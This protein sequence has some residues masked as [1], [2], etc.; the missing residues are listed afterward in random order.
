LRRH[1]QGYPESVLCD[2]LCN[3]N[4]LGVFTCMQFAIL[5]GEQQLQ[6]QILDIAGRHPKCVPSS[7]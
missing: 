2:V 5:V 7:V 1:Q 3:A 6:R 4:G